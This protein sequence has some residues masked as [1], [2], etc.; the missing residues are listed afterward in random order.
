VIPAPNG[1]YDFGK[2]GAG[3]GDVDGDG[4]RDLVVG[5]H[6]GDDAHVYLFLGGPAPDATP[7]ADL[8]GPNGFGQEL[9]AAGDFD[10]DGYGDVI[11]STSGFSRGYGSVWLLLGTADGLA[12]APALEYRDTAAWTS[13]GL[14]SAGGGDLD[15]DGFA[16]VAVGNPVLEE[17]PVFLG[18]ALDLEPDWRLTSAADGFGRGVGMLDAN[19]DGA[20]DLVATADGDDGP[21]SG[22]AVFF[23]GP[24]FDDVEDALILAPNDDGHFG[25]AVLRG[26]H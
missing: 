3:A 20:P 2:A 24:G 9:A 1:R 19:G 12:P 13:F 17:V 8:P 4:V 5:A 22:A 10:G 26:Y 6:S 14:T 11:T 25:T 7:D 23:G 15:G 16:D 18:G 21:R